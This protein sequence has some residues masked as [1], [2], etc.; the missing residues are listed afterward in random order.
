M[1]IAIRGTFAAYRLIACFASMIN[2][3]AEDA[4]KKTLEVKDFKERVRNIVNYIKR[5]VEASGDLKR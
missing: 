1:V 4:T 3:V 5:K 2:L